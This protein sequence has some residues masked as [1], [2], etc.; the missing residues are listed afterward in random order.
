MDAGQRPGLAV[1]V[2]VH[3]RHD[4]QQ[5]G[6]AGA[7]Q[8][9]HADLGAGEERQGDVAQDLA[10]R[11]HDFGDPVHGVDVLGHGSVKLEREQDYP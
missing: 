4:A 11:G 3:A 9:Q 8:T 7:V 6:F 10:L 2:G 1:D 5:G